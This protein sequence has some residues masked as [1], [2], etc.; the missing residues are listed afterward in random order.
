MTNQNA[1]CYFNHSMLLAIHNIFSASLICNQLLTWIALVWGQI[2]R[3]RNIQLHFFWALGSNLHQ[4]GCYKVCR[5]HSEPD[6]Y[7]RQQP[8]SST[9]FNVMTQEPLTLLKLR[10]LNL[11]ARPALQADIIHRPIIRGCSRHLR[12]WQK[13]HHTANITFNEQHFLWIFFWKFC[14]KSQFFVGVCA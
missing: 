7:N 14:I 6:K 9:S 4:S 2:W 10:I 5:R 12:C 11:Y 8:T 13:R 1:L 3:R